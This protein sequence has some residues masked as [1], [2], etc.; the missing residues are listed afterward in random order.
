MDS[1]APKPEAPDPRF[2]VVG[3][4]VQ[5]GR[6]CYIA[7]AAD[8]ELFRRLVDG[9]YCC[10]LAQRQVGKTSLAAAT[11]A[12]LRALDV[13][14]AVVDL[15]QASAENPTEN[16]GRWYYSI[17]YRILRDLRLR[18]DLQAWWAERGGLTN[19][20][21]LREFFQEMVLAETTGP[22]T[23]FL[24]RVE[25][26]LNVPLAQDLFACV[27]ACHDARATNPEFARL[28]FTLLSS[29]APRELV[30]SVRGSPFEIATRVELPDFSPQEMAALLAGL[31]P[32]PPLAEELNSRVWSWTRGHPYLSQKVYRGLARRS[33][34]QLYPGEVDELVRTQ[35]LTP[36]TLR[37]EPH[38]STIAAELLRDTPTRTARLNLYGRISKGIRVRSDAK[39][40]PEQ[41]L[42]VVGLVA[43]DAHGR[44]RVRNEIYGLVFDTR[45]ANEHLPFGVRTLVGAA[46]VLAAVIALPVWYTEY[47]PR[48]YVVAL[49][50]AEQD[51][52]VAAGAYNRLKQLPG[53]AATADRLYTSYLV[54]RGVRAP[55]LPAARAVAARLDPLP[56]GRELSRELL[57]GY[58]DRIAAR[59]MHAGDRDAALVSA[60]EALVQPTPQRRRRAGEL[61][62]A[63][64]VNLWGTLHSDSPV[65]DIVGDA[66]TGV[67]TLVTAGNQIDQWRL[68]APLPVFVRRAA[69]TAEERLP[70]ELRRYFERVPRRPRLLLAVQHEAP[71]QLEV[72]LR[73]PSGAQAVV[74]LAQARR[75]GNVTYAIDF[76]QQPELQQLLAGE[77]QGSWTLLVT[78]T[79]A[80][81]TGEVLG[82][83][84]IAGGAAPLSD[85]ASVQQP[86]PEPRASAAARVRLGAAGRLA[87]A[88]P[89]RVTH[90][91]VLQVWDL[92][93]ER[94]VARVP[95]T[96]ALRDAAFALGGRL[97][98]TLDGPTLRVFD[99][100]A[101]LSLGEIPFPAADFTGLALAGNGRFAAWAQSP[102]QGTGEP[103]VVVWDLLTM[104]EQGR[105]V[106]VGDMVALAVD[107]SGRRLAQG[108]RDNFVRVW[109]VPEARLTHEFVM[110][111]PAR[112]LQFD[113]AGRWLAVDDVRHTFRLW[114][115]EN[116]AAPVIER[117]GSSPWQTRF[118]ADSATLVLGSYDRAY[119][120]VYLPGGRVAAADL[121]HP[122]V[123]AEERPAQRPRP[124]LLPRQNRVI[125][126]D[127]GAGVKVW[128]LP[129]AAG[130]PVGERPPQMALS[131]DGELFAG[132]RALSDLRLRHADGSRVLALS[133]AAVT[134]SPDRP[135]ARPPEL[136]QLRF[137][138]DHRLLAAAATDGRARIWDTATG[139]P[140]RAPVVHADG[141]VLT[142]RF[143]ADGRYLLSASR[144]EVQV[145]D[146]QVTDV[147]VT[148]V[149][150]TDG[151]VD[152][153]QTSD[154][155]A[156]ATV[157]RL[158][159]QSDNPAIAYADATGQLFVANG[160]GSVLSWNWRSGAIATAVPASYR[161]TRL[162]VSA[163]GR[164]LLTAGA[165]FALR[166]WD[167]DT[168]T[169]L[170]GTVQAAGEVDALWLSANQRRLVV[171]AGHWLQSVAVMPAGLAHRHTRLL[172][173]EPA[174]LQPGPRGETALVLAAE[175]GA[176]LPVVQ[177]VDLTDPSSPPLAGSADELRPFWRSRLALDVTPEG[178]IVPRR[179]AA[180]PPV[181]VPASP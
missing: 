146:V 80:G 57:A 160:D 178:T 53:F 83:D 123:P 95:H 179:P 65:R 103:V 16:T 18:G 171:Q 120:V 52:G 154:L 55:T 148:D 2:Y 71:Q 30:P 6:D 113:A 99:T 181:G 29:A 180:I 145:T 51:P 147:Q 10:V 125:T 136:V 169:L 38:L 19:L 111:A 3:G 86:I 87:L 4:A 21:R 114:D 82:W 75:L 134:L 42:T 58:W 157:G 91:G 54:R 17:A 24:D 156:G 101:T 22:V 112:A 79:E 56:G 85:T 158:R 119:Q 122:A 118:A 116:T 92:G 176:S 76:E 96:P 62:G 170:P 49:T 8:A 109:S 117:V 124:V 90:S 141:P 46:M 138:N 174:A 110:S 41:E 34:E 26:T 15:T 11:A 97:V 69:V 94:V 35:F 139:Q 39:S 165:D 153:R 84:L 48:P 14:V 67:V 167:L 9:E 132:G 126:S 33:V 135:E 73:A 32:A 155:A 102:A 163:D 150:M 77:E 36:G 13:G 159:I 37:E 20:Q 105:I 130:A 66:E 31:G 173:T 131:G 40:V 68:D 108:G 142:V 149:Q 100:A 70:L 1:N 61:V 74:P 81:A 104:Q 128:S 161:V 27:R 59:R 47:L 175:A 63:D 45:W 64:Y 115:L 50:A 107:A 23:V 133:N 44:L 162:A 127:A 143:A 7:R 98:L 89:Q 168:G 88:W 164:R 172:S 12:K 166:Q 129:A 140:V 177:P 152:V 121:R 28:T 78:D 5:P 60:V 25:A 137:S 144:L 93:A 106:A 72:G 43:P 151:Q